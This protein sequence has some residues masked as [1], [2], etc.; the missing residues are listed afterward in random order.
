MP[1]IIFSF[2]NFNKIIRKLSSLKSKSFFGLHTSCHLT[3]SSTIS[4][5]IQ[6]AERPMFPSYRNQSVASLCK[7]TDWFL[8]DG[9]MVVKG[10]K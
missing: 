5:V 4:K 2:Q 10:L 6:K 7:S 8:Y 9:S 3:D 1:T